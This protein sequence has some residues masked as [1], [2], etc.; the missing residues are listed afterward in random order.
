MQTPKKTNSDSVIKW[1]DRHFFSSS[2]LNAILNRTYWMKAMMVTMALATQAM[3]V[4][5][6]S[7]LNAFCGGEAFG[8][9]PLGYL[10]PLVSLDE[11]L[12]VLYRAP[13]AAMRL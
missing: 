11:D 3:T 1:I 2:G 7:N 13:G 4:S 8:D 12:A 6:K 10:V 9:Q 5:W